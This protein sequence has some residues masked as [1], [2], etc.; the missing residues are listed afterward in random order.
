M[1]NLIN[2]KGQAFSTFQLLIAAVVALAL[3]GV[4]MPIIMGNFSI[5]K[6]PSDSAQQYAKTQINNAGSLGYTDTLKF[7]K[8]DSISATGVADGIDVDRDQVYVV[9][10][11]DLIDITFS[12]PSTS[13]YKQTKYLKSTKAD[14]K[15]G[16][17]CDY[18]E[19]IEVSLG[20]NGLT[21]GPNNEDDFFSIIKDLDD[22]KDLDNS[23]K[24]CI[25]FPKRG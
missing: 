6:S 13:S 5:G 4:L 19:S 7:K 23:I 9:V 22:F 25:L 3:L 1:S 24:V 8:D 2:Q 18:K 10:P 15:I 11:T 16:V 12:D 20:Y 17:I 21:G 14:Y